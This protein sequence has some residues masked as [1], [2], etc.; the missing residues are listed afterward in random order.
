M[1]EIA[2]G[3]IVV[4]VEDQEIHVADGDGGRLLHGTAR[5][6]TTDTLGIAK[7]SADVN[8]GG[9]ELIVTKAQFDVIAGNTYGTH[10]PPP[11]LHAD[12]IIPSGRGAGSGIPVK[13]IVSSDKATILEDIWGQLHMIGGSQYGMLGCGLTNV[14]VTDGLHTLHLPNMTGKVVKF[15]TCAESCFVLFDDGELY[16]WGRNDFKQLGLGHADLT[17]YPSLVRSDV[18]DFWL[19][20]FATLDNGKFAYLIATVTDQLLMNGYGSVGYPVGVVAEPMTDWTSITGDHVAVSPAASDWK[21]WFYG[22]SMSMLAL[23]HKT[24]HELFV[25]SYGDEFQSGHRDFESTAE[26]TLN[27]KRVEQD[28]R[29]SGLSVISGIGSDL[30][31]GIYRNG[32]LEFTPGRGLNIA[33]Y[34]P[35]TLELKTYFYTDTKS[36]SEECGIYVNGMGLQ[37]EPAKGSVAAASTRMVELL[38]SHLEDGDLYVVFVEDGHTQ[39]STLSAELSASL[40]LDDITLIGTSE[41]YYGFGI[42]GVGSEFTSGEVKLTANHATSLD[43]IP[44]API[45][46]IVTAYGDKSSNGTI[47]KGG[48]TFLLMESGELFA[49]GGSGKMAADHNLPLNGWTLLGDADGTALVNV[50]KVITGGRG[51]GIA[52]IILDDNT[53]L[54]QGFDLNGALA[55]NTG[56]GQCF[57]DYNVW[58]P[59]DFGIIDIK[60]PHKEFSSNEPQ[61]IMEITDSSVFEYWFVG[62]NDVGLGGSGVSGGLINIP[63]KITTLPNLREVKSI[64]FIVNQIG[65]T[66]DSSASSEVTAL[67]NMDN[68]ELWAL[69]ANNNG[70]LTGIFSNKVTAHAS[71]AKRLL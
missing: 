70:S 13:G 39:D 25:C 69:G 37:N 8:N 40:G 17:P 52:A 30:H 15:D 58:T 51:D 2:K 53:M 59:V 5:P 28:V 19:P 24:T 41:R 7:A 65:D 50:A 1:T 31:C 36:G 42:V 55:P 20:E 16:A 61:V 32:K 10:N 48:S 12:D 45:K 27:T 60:I 29:I 44:L 35:V 3:T 66:A 62:N 56:D 71:S 57:T 63:S 64:N 11:G 4:D 18:V 26:Y 22:D 23:Q 9:D 46:E 38:G 14:N 68:D 6:A 47:G 33:A 49:C 43:T 67:F 54:T 21:V 34:D